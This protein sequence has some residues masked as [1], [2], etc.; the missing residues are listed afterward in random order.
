MADQVYTPNG[1]VFKREETTKDMT[2]SFKDEK[3]ILVTPNPDHNWLAKVAD[4][5]GY[6]GDYPIKL[7]GTLMHI[8]SKEFVDLPAGH[9]KLEVWEVWTDNG[10]VNR[11]LYPSPGSFVQ[12][13]IESNITD[14]KGDISKTISIDKIV[15]DIAQKASQNITISK[16][17]MAD[18]GTKPTVKKTATEAGVDFELTIPKG[19]PGKDGNDGKDAVQPSF[20]VT[21][22][23]LAS[24][25]QPTATIMPNDDKTSFLINLGLVQGVQ[26][27]QGKPGIQ[28]EPGPAGKNF[29]IKK[30]FDSVK[31]MTDSKGEGITEGDFVLIASG[32]NDEDNAKLYVW[33]GTEF[34]YLVDMSGAQGIKGDQGIPGPA[35]SFKPGT[36]TALPSDAKPTFEVVGD[37][38][39]YTINIGIPQGVK[40]DQ[41]DPGADGKS[42]TDGHTP[43]KGTDYWT[44][45]DKQAI[46][47]EAKKYV[48]DAI[49]N[50]KW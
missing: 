4:E 36:V 7:D 46:Y 13:T 31:S 34:K 32:V 29:D 19:D 35:A 25:Q 27:I 24:D 39:T 15:S 44:D 47:A 1:T 14:S 21:A 3:G 5:K 20:E 9:Y 38:G 33:T 40:G 16:V 10:E 2:I 48:D 17:I 28:G 37:N 23:Q 45:A 30:T 12:F 8:S 18:S 22:T 50:G 41:G 49:L 43:E 6:I 11:T 26:G 42:G